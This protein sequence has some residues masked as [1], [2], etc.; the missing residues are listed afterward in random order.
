MASF[1]GFG[2]AEDPKF[3]VI[4]RVKRPRASEW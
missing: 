4:V 3:V 1:A 2:P